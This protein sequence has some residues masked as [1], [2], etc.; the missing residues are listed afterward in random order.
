MLDVF[1]DIEGSSLYFRLYVEFYRIV[2]IDERFVVLDPR[3]VE[4]PAFSR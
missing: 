1:E 2:S 4:E 3:H